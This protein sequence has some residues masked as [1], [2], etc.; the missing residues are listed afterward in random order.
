MFQASGEGVFILISGVNLPPYHIPSA[1]GVCQK[2]N[3]TIKDSSFF[4]LL[5]LLIVFIY[6]L[7]CF[8]GH[9][10]TDIP[11]LEPLQCTL[12]TD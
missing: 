5:L 9:G 6:V 8:L 4:A 12:Y 3:E 1:G 10:F 2:Y 7:F 11:H